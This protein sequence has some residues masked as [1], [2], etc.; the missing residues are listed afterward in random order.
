VQ[1][2]LTHHAGVI[3]SSLPEE[4]SG[5]PNPSS[6]EKVQRQNAAVNAF[7]GPERIPARPPEHAT[8]KIKHTQNMASTPCLEMNRRTSS[9]LRF[10]SQATPTWQHALM[11]QCALHAQLTHGPR[12][13]QGKP[14]CYKTCHDMSYDANIQSL[15]SGCPRTPGNAEEPHLAPRVA[16]LGTLR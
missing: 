12:L 7:R 1:P 10:K 11:L 5:L 14:L 13:A 16:C 6:T 9:N 3:T 15:S 2:A 4:L 8:C